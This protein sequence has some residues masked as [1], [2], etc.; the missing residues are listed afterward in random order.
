METT[1][2]TTSVTGPG[3]QLRLAREDLRLAPEDVAHILHLSPRQILALE[4]DRYDSLPGATYVRGYLRS[5]A[6]LLGLP[7]D[8]VVEAYNRL[9]AARKPVDL[10]KLTP[11]PEVRSDH[12]VIQITSVVVITIVLG[13]A[14][15]WWRGEETPS[16]AVP[17]P[18]PEPTAPAP[19]AA[20]PEP[21]PVV[22]PAAPK[23]APAGAA[24]TQTGPQVAGATAPA[25]RTIAAP[26]DSIAA[27]APRGRLVLHVERES[28]ADVRD[29]RDNR[30]L[31]EIVPAGSAI[32]IEGP[33]PLN[34]FLGNVDG[35]RV[36]FNGAPYDALRHRRGAVARFTLGE[37]TG[38]E[39]V[40]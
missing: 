38:G 17:A 1:T 32:A 33:A 8:T 4:N 11:P 5:Y 37:P 26:A 7:A 20:A 15:V 28:W 21:P 12:H 24:K 13:L 14:A 2:P 6:Q 19:P 35:V 23:P 29:A 27:G 10:G 25:P 18:M 39:H 40:R 16:R 3:A 31:Y 36:E 34:V 22:A 30:L 9:T